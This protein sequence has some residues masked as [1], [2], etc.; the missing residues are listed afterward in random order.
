[1]RSV[2]LGWFFLIDGVCDS[3]AYIGTEL[4]SLEEALNPL[5]EALISVE[6][7]EATVA[8]EQRVIAERLERDRLEQERTV[9]ARQKAE[10]LEREN[11]EKLAMEREAALQAEKSRK[12]SVFLF[13]L[14]M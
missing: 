1:M 12:E 8:A 14:I 3:H 6:N 4:E 13:Y 11:E 7:K 5:W 10:A 9:I 2:L